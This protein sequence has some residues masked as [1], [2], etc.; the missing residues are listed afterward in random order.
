M[1]S[2]AKQQPQV[3]GV[4]HLDMSPRNFCCVWFN[5]ALQTH[6]LLLG[7]TLTHFQFP[8]VTNDAA[9]LSSNC[10]LN[11]TAAELGGAPLPTVFPAMPYL[12]SVACASVT[13]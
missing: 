9:S 8:N 1:G 11:C 3:A 10:N 7:L 5:S 13:R 12:E 6:P 2:E 4:L